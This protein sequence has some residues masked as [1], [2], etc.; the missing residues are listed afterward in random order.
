MQKTTSPASPGLV[1]PH[2]EQVFEIDLEVRYVEEFCFG[3]FFDPA[4]VRQAAVQDC[5]RNP[6]DMPS[7]VGI[8]TQGT[9]QLFTALVHKYCSASGIQQLRLQLHD[10]P[11]LL[12]RFCEMMLL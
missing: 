9:G 5:P 12:V 7:F 11:A 3:C 2:I 8:K 1:S 6:R 4:A 10:S